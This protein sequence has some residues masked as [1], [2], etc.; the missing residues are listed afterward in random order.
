MNSFPL[1]ILNALKWWWECFG[2]KLSVNI[3]HISSILMHTSAKRRLKIAH[4][5]AFRPPWC[6]RQEFFETKR[7]CNFSAYLKINST[8]LRIY[9]A[10]LCC[11][12][13]FKVDSRE[14]WLEKYFI[15]QQ[16]SDFSFFYSFFSYTSFSTSQ[17]LGFPL[18]TTVCRQTRTW[19]CARASWKR[20]ISSTKSSKKKK[21]VELLE[22][23]KK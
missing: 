10:L 22:R 8:L 6:R 20:K 4:K 15:S 5:L 7:L 3:K 14:K 9:L 18:S 21:E 11:K 13:E 17:S 23:H 19:A 2:Y 1:K 12:M 16:W